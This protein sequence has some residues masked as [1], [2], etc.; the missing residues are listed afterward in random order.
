MKH[1]RWLNVL[2]IIIVLISC[3]KIDQKKFEN[4]HHAI[5]QIEG[6]VMAGVNYMKFGELLQNLATELLITKDKVK[7]KEERDLLEL[8]DKV[9]DTY[10]DSY[11]LWN[12]KIDWNRVS[13][14]S[15]RDKTEYEYLEHFFIKKY[16]LDVL[17][18]YKVGKV[19]YFDSAIQKIWNY[20]S[21]QYIGKIDSQ[22]KQ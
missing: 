5:K 9:Y 3:H 20:A 8:Y 15:E 2:F 22:M 1:I 19:I 13:I 17:D 11:T 4:L 21:T 7:T 10:K 16:N 14:D 6:S 12:K 18:V